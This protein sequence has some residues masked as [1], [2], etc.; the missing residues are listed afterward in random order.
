MYTGPWRDDDPRW[1]PALASQAHLTK[2]DDGV[3][4]IEP[5][6]FQFSFVDF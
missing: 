3:F 5:K 4:F 6:A 2:A 1:T